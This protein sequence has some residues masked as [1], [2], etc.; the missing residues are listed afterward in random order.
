M[1]SNASD[2]ED[3][4]QDTFLKAWLNLSTFRF[5]AKFST[6]ITSVAMNEALGS[7]RRRRCRP[8]CPA[9]VNFETFH[10][11]SESPEQALSRSEARRTIRSAVAS[12]PKK[13]REILT[14][15]E[16]EQLSGEEAARRLKSSLSSVKA[17]LFRGRHM[18][19]ARL[20]RDVA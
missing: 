4:V 8:F 1:V 15:C 3:L 20:R 11:S 18:L 2:V 7:Y 5:E 10:S 12:L 14:L 6:W 17:R 19:Y 16:L 13:Y 9:P